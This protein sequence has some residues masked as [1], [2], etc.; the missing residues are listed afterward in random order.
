MSVTYYT[1][2]HFFEKYTGVAN[3]VGNDKVLVDR[4]QY[5]DVWVKWDGRWVIQERKLARMVSGR[6]LL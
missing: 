2:A 3:T 1:A 4:S 5:L 6:T